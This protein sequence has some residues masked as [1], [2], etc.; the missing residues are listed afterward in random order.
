MEFALPGSQS[1]VSDER[2]PWPAFRPRPFPWSRRMQIPAPPSIRPAA[3]GRRRKEIASP[4]C[5]ADGKL[6]AWLLRSHSV[7]APKDEGLARNQRLRYSG[8]GIVGE[9]VAIPG[10]PGPGKCRFL[11]LC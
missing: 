5:L 11:L 7:P 1:L 8:F 3:R 2:R 10:V 6:S 4:A 9:A